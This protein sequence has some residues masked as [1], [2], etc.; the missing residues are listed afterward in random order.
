MAGRRD[1][2]TSKKCWRLGESPS[3]TSVCMPHAA[4]AYNNAPA[5]FE[6]ALKSLQKRADTD[7]SDVVSKIRRHSKDL[8]VTATRVEEVETGDA[9]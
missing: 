2:S 9:A 3:S 1:N 5:A 4:C 6:T 8:G 7:D